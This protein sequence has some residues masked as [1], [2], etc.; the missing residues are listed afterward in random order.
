MG[1]YTKRMTQWWITLTLPILARNAQSDMRTSFIRAGRERNPQKRHAVNTR[2][3]S[4]LRHSYV[5][6]TSIK[7]S[8]MTP[9][10]HTRTAHSPMI[11]A[12]DRTLAD[13]GTGG[14]QA[15]G[16]HTG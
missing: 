16:R 15:L 8:R 11:L 6:H 14:R 7:H 1:D 9:D 5:R 3:T 12:S 10:R 4:L 13:V 2:M